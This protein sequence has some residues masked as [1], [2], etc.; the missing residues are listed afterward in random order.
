MS[1]AE[2]HAVPGWPGIKVTRDGRLAGPMGERK[3]RPHKGGYL[4]IQVGKRRR[5]L[6]VSHAVLFAFV[7]PCPPDKTEARHR[8]GV[9]TDNRVENLSWATHAENLADQIEHGTRPR[10]EDKPQA[11]LTEA[12]V[13][14]I[15]RDTRSTTVL[16][17]EY[18]VS[19]ETVRQIKHRRKWAHV[20]DDAA[21]FADVQAAR[22]GA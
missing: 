2:W 22:G 3:L 1:A 13:R 15:R 4:C 5:R 7:G 9:R 12:D 17:R 6:W 14:A 10:G 19:A 20:A 8:N 18:G 11:K 16:G 21:A